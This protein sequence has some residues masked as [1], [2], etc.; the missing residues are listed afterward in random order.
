MIRM[1]ELAS[2]AL[3]IVQVNTYILMSAASWLGLQG[4]TEM[5]EED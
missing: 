5:L 2:C 3:K 4:V 1:Y